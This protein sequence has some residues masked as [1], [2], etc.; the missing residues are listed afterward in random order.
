MPKP[1]EFVRRHPHAVQVAMLAVR[2]GLAMGAAQL[3]VALP[4]ASL[5]ALRAVT[6]TLLMDTLQLSCE[7]AAEGG[8]APADEAAGSSTAAA[9]VG[10]DSTELTETQVAIAQNTSH[11]L[12]SEFATRPP[13][14][15][16]SSLA[17][18][19]SH[20]EASRREYALLK[21]WLEQL[22][23]GWEARCGLAPVVQADG[24]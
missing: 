8:D 14:D 21:Q 4:A 6:D 19:R 2:A 16:L 3:G 9:G 5:D 20:M 24:R 10:G 18:D 13:D 11:F 7:A 23:P 22:H 1:Y 17:A 12:Q 15:V